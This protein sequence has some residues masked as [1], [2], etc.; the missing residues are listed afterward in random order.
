MPTAGVPIAR[1]PCTS[2]LLILL[3]VVS[4]RSD[5][6]GRR[7]LRPSRASICVGLDRPPGAGRVLRGLAVLVPVLLDRVEDL[8][9][10]FH[11]LRAGEEVGVA[12]QHIEDQPLVRLRAGLREGLAVGEVHRDV[13][14]L[15]RRAGDLGAEADRDAL[16]RLDAD[17]DRVGPELLGGGGVEGGVRRPLEDDRDLRDPAAETLAGAQV[18][19]D[20]RPAAVVHAQLDGRVGVGLRRWGR[21]RPPRGSRRPSRRPASPPRTGRARCR[22][23]GPSAAAPRRA[24]WASRRPARPR[25]RRPAPPWR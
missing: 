15:H 5:L 24:P 14:D 12:E 7:Q 23:P 4:V 21:C 25:R 8:P 6:H 1:R 2:A 17:D 3:A 16:V 13:P 19:R 22:C 11:L 10:Q 20:A 9:G 18:E